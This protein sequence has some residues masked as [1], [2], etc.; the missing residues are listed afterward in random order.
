[1]DATRRT[2]L[3]SERTL[4]AWVRTGLASTAVAL[5]VG[6]LVPAV[7]GAEHRW[8]YVVVGAGYALYGAACVMFGF[9]RER[10]L[11]RAVGEGGFVPLGTRA[12]ASFGLAGAGLALATALLVIVAP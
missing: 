5:G 6:R 9:R 4:L 10:A 1:M 12:T 8:P 7:T 2:F 11:D 3:A